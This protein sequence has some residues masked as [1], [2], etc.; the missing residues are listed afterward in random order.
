MKSYALEVA[1]YCT[2]LGC[3][4]GGGLFSLFTLIKVWKHSDVAW[5]LTIFAL[6]YWYYLVNWLYFGKYA[7]IT[8]LFYSL[9][10]L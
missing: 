7:F 9:L 5:T 10:Q 4:V 3:V 2:L 8:N 1:T 6:F